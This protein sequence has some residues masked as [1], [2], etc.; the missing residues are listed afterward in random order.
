MPSE[1]SALK[2]LQTQLKQAQEE[3]LEAQG[4][5]RACDLR[6]QDLNQQINKLKQTRIVVSEHAMLR[7]LERIHGIDLEEVKREILSDKIREQIVTLGDG[8][9][10][11]GD[12]VV[13]VKGNTVVTCYPL[14]AACSAPA[15]E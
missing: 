11:N 9:Y 4:K 5:V 10:P 1:S 15:A 2:S 14:E 6:I 12:I 7:Y 8:A 3:R 13:R